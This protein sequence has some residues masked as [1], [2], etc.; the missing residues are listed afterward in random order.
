MQVQLVGF[1]TLT[2]LVFGMFI[3][4]IFG[5]LNGLLAIILSILVAS[6]L[7]KKFKNREIDDPEFTS[8][9]A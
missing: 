3:G 7:A 9:A 1:T 2:I 6:L 4:S 5:V 8:V